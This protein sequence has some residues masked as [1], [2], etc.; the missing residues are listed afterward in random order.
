MSKCGC[1]YSSAACEE[2]KR[3]FAEVR[4]AYQGVIGMLQSELVPLTQDQTWDEY[5]RA[6]DA[7]FEHIGESGKVMEW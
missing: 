2:G 3:L 7:Y 1:T 4:H 5:E 6:R